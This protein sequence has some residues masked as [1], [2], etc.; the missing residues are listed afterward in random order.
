MKA[1]ADAESRSSRI[2]TSFSVVV[3]ALAAL[4][5]DGTAAAADARSVTIGVMSGFSGPYAGPAEDQWRAAQLAAEQINAQGGILGREIKL[6]RRDDKLNPGEAGKM[7]QDMIQKDRPDFII[8]AN[9]AGTILPVNDQT[10]KAGIPY[11]AIA[12]N[13]RVTTAADRGP[14]TFHE[15]VTPTMSGRSLGYWIAK[16]LGKKVYYLMADYAFGKDTYAAMSK[17]V[18]EAG[19][20][21][22]GVAYFPLGTTDFTPFIAKVRAANADVV[23]CASFGNDTINLLKQAQRFELT[24]QSKFFFPVVDLQGDLAIGYENLAGTYGGSN[25]YWELA[26]KGASAKRFVEAYTKRWSTPP[27]GYAG[28]AYSAMFVVKAAAERAKSTDP[29]KFSKALEGLEYDFYKGKQWIRA[30][31]HQAFQPL[32][33]VKGRT[34]E[35]AKKLGR[36]QYGMR[37]IVGTVDP[38]ESTERTCQEL[39]Y[40]GEE[41]TAR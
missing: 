17:A 12:Q 37:E 30:C 39:G 29:A 5:G 41:R 16:N 28:Y 14:Y 27:S 15:A 33:I 31:D 10:K 8:S 24:K 32:F 6:V 11:I 7:A 34:L 20:N 13:D 35:E 21:E 1:K 40:P 23:V 25:F 9:S 22:A 2:V 18:L 4:L 19:G 36:E 26:D 3:I 38:S